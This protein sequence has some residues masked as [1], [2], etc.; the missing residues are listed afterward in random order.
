M[1]VRSRDPAAAIQDRSNALRRWYNRV[2]VAGY[3]SG[4]AGAVLYAW[5]VGASNARRVYWRSAPRC[6]C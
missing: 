3:V 6:S 5:D 4:L 1:S 2:R